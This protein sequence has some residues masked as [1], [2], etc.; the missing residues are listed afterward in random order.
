MARVFVTGFSSSCRA[1]RAVH[2]LARH[3][4]VRGPTPAGPSPATSVAS[5]LCLSVAGAALLFLNGLPFRRPSHDDMLKWLIITMPLAAY[6]WYE[7]SGP[8]GLTIEGLRHAPVTH[9]LPLLIIIAFAAIALR[10]GIRRRTHAPILASMICIG[11]AAFELR[12][13]T[14]LS[15][16]VKLIFWGCASLLLVMGLDKYLRTPR[17]G[18]TSN[19]FGQSKGSLDLLQFLGASALA[20]QTSQHPNAQF[21][22]GGGT[23]GGGGASGN[24]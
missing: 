17:R 4:R 2:A 20:A 10:L 3:R 24:Y 5:V 12:N 7:S 16:K 21:K 18:I 23:G 19:Q 9:L 13:F 1:V 6:L 8:S 14:P 15:L 22:G 11:C